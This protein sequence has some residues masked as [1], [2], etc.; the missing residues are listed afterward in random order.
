MSFSRFVMIQECLKSG[1]GQ[2]SSMRSFS[3]DKST[4]MPRYFNGSGGNVMHV[5]VR[6]MG[7]LRPSFDVNLV[8][9][10]FDVIGTHQF[11]IKY[12]R[13]DRESGIVNFDLSIQ[14]TCQG[15]QCCFFFLVVSWFSPTNEAVFLPS[16]IFIGGTKY[17]EAMKL[18]ETRHTRSFVSVQSFCLNHGTTL[19]S[20]LK[21]A[22]HVGLTFRS[23]MIKH[24]E[25]VVIGYHSKVT[26]EV[27][28]ALAA[29]QPS[30][31]ECVTVEQTRIDASNVITVYGA[32]IDRTFYYNRHAAHV[33]G[34]KKAAQS[35]R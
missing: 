18:Q 12:E 4:G 6:T 34:Q 15:Q 1:S 23:F 25:P 32:P 30:P 3:R 28:A 2:E 16:P 5:A 19:A 7:F 13:I 35:R 8:T 33:A 22:P 21:A 26:E 10:S 29:C 27:L 31:H 17:T 14:A 20:F 11:S 24:T 9:D